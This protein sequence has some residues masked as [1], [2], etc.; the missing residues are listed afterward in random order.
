VRQE[1]CDRD[2]FLGIGSN[3]RPR[4]TAARRAHER[5]RPAPPFCVPPNPSSSYHPVMM[6]HHSANSTSGLFDGFSDPPGAFFHLD[7]LRG[8]ATSVDSS[9]YG[10]QGYASRGGSDD[11]LRVA[12]SAEGLSL[13]SIHTESLLPQSGPGFDFHIPHWVGGGSTGLSAARALQEPGLRIQNAAL[14]PNVPTLR[15]GLCA[16]LDS[17]GLLRCKSEDAGSLAWTSSNGGL[18]ALTPVSLGGGLVQGTEEAEINP[19]GNE[20]VAPPR[21]HELDFLSF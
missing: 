5:A 4:T 20:F 9:T 18:G 11:F 13:H 12:P 19:R 16:D 15:T 7:S 21:N 17:K 6:H 3:K 10:Y 8:L 14:N 1:R 2:Q